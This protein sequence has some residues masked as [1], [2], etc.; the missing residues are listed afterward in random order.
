MR[1][2]LANQ[3]VILRLVPSQKSEA[4]R[5]TR[6]QGNRPQFDSERLR[7][8]YQVLQIL[9]KVRIP[10]SSK[11]LGLNPTRAPRIAMADYVAL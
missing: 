4:N 5:P 1:A 6:P 2:S 10:Q 3:V 9:E 8:S 11:E 7:A